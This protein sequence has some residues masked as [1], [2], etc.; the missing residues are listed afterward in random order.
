LNPDSAD[1]RKLDGHG[2]VLGV[3]H[4]LYDFMTAAVIHRVQSL[5]IT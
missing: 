4:C 5:T 3:M 2:V 1:C